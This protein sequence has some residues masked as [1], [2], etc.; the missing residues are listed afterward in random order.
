MTES[1]PASVT[2]ALAPHLVCDGAAN[3]IDFYTTAFGA[4]ELIRI[5]ADN[6][7]LLHAC[8][9]I[10]GAPVMLVDEFPGMC[11]SNSPKTLKGTP[12]TIH[13]NVSNVDAFV[14][15]A[16]DAGAKE[17]V[18]VTD[19]FWGDRY[20]VIEDPFG[21]NWSVATPNKKMT[22]E[23]IQSAARQAMASGDTTGKAQ[24]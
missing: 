14:K 15:K 1:K 18:P 3:A 11:G 13:L 4:K 7:K 8:V 21:H 17:I 24:D 10:N 12:V 23:E 20:G 9:E 2:F 16:L 19:M 22:A 6:G 5:P